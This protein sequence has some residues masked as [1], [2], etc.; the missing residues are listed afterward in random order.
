MAYI[1]QADLPDSNDVVSITLSSGGDALEVAR[2]W[3]ADGNKSVRI[4]GDGRIYFVE[5]FERVI[6]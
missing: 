3:V 2:R 4:I 5:E 6:R 1:V